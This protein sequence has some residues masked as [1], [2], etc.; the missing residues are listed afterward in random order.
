MVYTAPLI[1]GTGVH[2][3][4]MSSVVDISAQK[5]AEAR[6]HLQAQQVQHQQRRLILGEM[7]T[8]IAHEMNQPLMAVNLYASV[9]KDYL[10][11]GDMVTL[12]GALD[13]VQAQAQRA[14]AVLRKIRGHL[15]PQTEDAG[16]LAVNDLVTDALALLKLQIRAQQTRIDTDLQPGLP[17][18]RGD[19]TLLEQVVLNLMLNGLQAMRGTP[20]VQRR[21]EI[22]T[23]LVEGFV[24]VRVS[25]HGP[26]IGPE[27]AAKM[28]EP[29]FT[30]KPD[31]FGLGLSICRTII[32]SHRGRLSFANRPDGGAVW[33]VW[34]AGVRCPA[35]VRE[36]DRRAFSFG[37][38]HD[39]GCHRCHPQRRVRLAGETVHRY[40]TAGENRRGTRAG[41]RCR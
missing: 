32:E 8:T 12:K 29:F 26:G 6:E 28:F 41:R 35:P 37:Y 21:L 20:L 5:R 36:P 7:V 39:C 9:A 30:A 10:A 31:G 22:D 27:V 34:V 18:V 13:D 40:R 38:R 19:R 4:W 25:D 17:L 15:Q 14:G 33:H 23:S 11:L 16:E 2:K 1:D 24:Q 3:G